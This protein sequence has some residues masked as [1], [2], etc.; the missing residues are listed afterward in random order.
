MQYLLDTSIAIRAGAAEPGVME[1]FIKHSGALFTSALVLA[2]LHRG[3]YKNPAHQDLRRMQLDILL[4]QVAVLKF[5]AA[6]AETYG[7]IIAQLGWVKGRDFDRMIAAHA[8]SSRS[9]L[10]TSN[11]ADFRDVPGLELENWLTGL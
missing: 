10:V 6:A 5:D 2:E 8:I 11:E 3:F 7:R 1:K 9:I 4:Q